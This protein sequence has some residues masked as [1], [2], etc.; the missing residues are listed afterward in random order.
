MG[1][2]AVIFSS[3]M[4]RVRGENSVLSLQSLCAQK[5]CSAGKEFKCC[6]KRE[7]EAEEED[8]A[9]PVAKPVTWIDENIDRFKF[10]N[11]GFSV[12]VWQTDQQP[13]NSETYHFSANYI[14]RL[15]R[16]G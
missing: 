12:G 4:L 16:R 3:G 13:C 14:T 9:E 7:E 10:T 1:F 6:V 15:L 2:N 11:L 8:L 5:I